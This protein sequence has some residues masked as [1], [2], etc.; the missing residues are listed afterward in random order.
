MKDYTFSLPELRKMHVN[1]GK[2]IKSL[3]KLAKNKERL[4]AFHYC[5]VG[6]SFEHLTIYQAALIVLQRADRPLTTEEVTSAILDGGKRLGNDAYDIVSAAL[7]RVSYTK[8]L[9][10]RKVG[11]SMWKYSKNT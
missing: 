6:N 3:E 9:K 8:R 4:L 10:I 7:Y 5:W 11:K 1:I 2:A